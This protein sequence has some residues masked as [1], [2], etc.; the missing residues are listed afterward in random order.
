MSGGIAKSVMLRILWNRRKSSQKERQE[1]IFSQKM[2]NKKEVEFSEYAKNLY[3]NSLV[4]GIPEIVIAGNCKVRLIRLAVFICCIAGFI[5][6]SLDFMDLY[7]KYPTILDIQITRK[8]EIMMPAVTAC[9][10]NGVRLSLYCKYFPCKEPVSERRFCRCYPEGR[11][12]NKKKRHPGLLVPIKIGDISRTFFFP[13]EDR[14]HMMPHADDFITS[15]SLNR[16]PSTVFESCGPPQEYDPD[17]MVMFK[18][19]SLHS[20]YSLSNPFIEG[21]F[22][23]SERSYKIYVKQTVKHLMK[24]PYDT[25]CFDYLEEWRKNGG[26]GPMSESDCI[27]ECKRKVQL[28]QSDGCVTTSVWYPS[29]DKRCLAT[30]KICA[31]FGVSGAEE[32]KRDLLCNM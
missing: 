17:M 21:L 4:T 30:T 19:I 32:C 26:R 3:G 18:Q 22:L 13:Q 14:E 28:S 31:D 10:A 12:C 15:C 5:Y 8:G 1:E 27:Q 24:P 25:K 9:D 16:P 29:N 2:P 7:W 23:H 20:P 6:Q 11:Y